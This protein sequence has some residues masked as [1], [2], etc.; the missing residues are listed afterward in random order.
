M[1]AANAVRYAI[2]FLLATAVL[3]AI[4]VGVLLILVS[5]WFA[6]QA[7]ALEAVG[8]AANLATFASAIGMIL[9]VGIT[10]WY[11]YATHR[12]TTLSLNQQSYRIRKEHTDTLRERVD[13]W[14]G[15]YDERIDVYHGIPRVQEID[16]VSAPTG[17]LQPE[18]DEFRVY[19]NSLEGDKFLDDLLQNH[20]EELA[21]LIDDIEDAQSKFESLRDDFNDGYEDTEPLDSLP[22]K[23]EP[24]KS[25]G[26]WAFNQALWI[27][28]T[29]LDEEDLR[30]MARR[31][32]QHQ[33]TSGDGEVHFRPGNVTGPAI[34][35]DQD[36]DIDD[37]K[38]LAAL[39]DLVRRLPDQ[40]VYH[41]AVEAAGMLDEL[42]GLC[43]E[44]R[45]TL[46][47]YQGRVVY[48]GEC[49]YLR[50]AS[51]EPEGPLDQ[52]FGKFE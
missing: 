42:E 50:E 44:L 1:E 14:L 52:F 8:L 17:S 35:G 34:V 20:A 7:I 37:E 48:G 36:E 41:I 33:T 43:D 25:Y 19:P 26:Y 28:R 45:R 24:G 21:Q 40:E 13:D 23:A 30:N 38:L 39:M 47:E 5:I 46:D 9:L 32:V 29:D 11:A 31:T 22:F 12:G 27:E 3:S 4:I 51:V 18:R 2:Y 10:T 16:V 6:Y 49:E 15:E